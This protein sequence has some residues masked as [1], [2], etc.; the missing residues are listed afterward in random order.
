M[1]NQEHVIDMREITGL[2]KSSLDQSIMDIYTCIRMCVIIF[3]WYETLKTC[4]MKVRHYY[5]LSDKLIWSISHDYVY[6]Y[7]NTK[8]KSVLYK[9]KI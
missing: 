1:W 9:D 3:L 6:P 2:V 4:Y 8:T 7:Y 5:L